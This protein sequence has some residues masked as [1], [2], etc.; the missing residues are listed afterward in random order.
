MSKRQEE[1]TE[2]CANCRHCLAYPRN[3]RYRDIDHLCAVSG[4][5]VT[6]IHKDRNKVRGFSPGGR[7]LEC[8][9]E[10][11]QNNPFERAAAVLS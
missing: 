7:E 10:R 9:Y 2:C 3:N 11:K 1:L 4:Y 5:F 6:G 8:R